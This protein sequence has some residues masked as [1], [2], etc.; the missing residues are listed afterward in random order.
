[1]SQAS[2]SLWQLRCNTCIACFSRTLWSSHQLNAEKPVRDSTIRFVQSFNR[3][4]F[5]RWTLRDKAAQ[6]RLALLEPLKLMLLKTVLLL[7]LFPAVA[8]ALESGDTCTNATKLPPNM[9]CFNDLV[10]DCKDHNGRGRNEDLMCADAD[11]QA[12][13]KRLNQTYQRILGRLVGESRV[14]LVEAQ[15]AWV[16]FK[17]ADC[18]DDAGHETTVA[19]WLDVFVA[20]CEAELTKQRL[21]T[22]ERRY[23]TK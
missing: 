20:K 6:R 11:R 1:M 4:P 22:L 23:G 10:L 14:S 17:L 15:R 5:S 7:V 13:D 18:Q 12:V 8:L 21:Q 3:A 9:L 2:L 19:N 16:R